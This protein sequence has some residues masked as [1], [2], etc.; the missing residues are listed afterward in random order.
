MR[1]DQKGSEHIGRQ[2]QGSQRYKEAA[3]TGPLAKKMK[4][5]R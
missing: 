2:N 4:S 5:S 1:E 3:V